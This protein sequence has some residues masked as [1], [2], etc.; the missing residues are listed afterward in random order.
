MPTTYFSGL[1]VAV[2]WGW[3][4]WRSVLGCCLAVLHCLAVG[5][6]QLAW[7]SV[8]CILMGLF[9]VLFLHS[10]RADPWAADRFQPYTRR[11][12]V[13]IRPD[14]PGF[15]WHVCSISMGL[16][17]VLFMHSH[18]ADPWA[19]DRFQPYTRRCMVCIRPDMP[20]F[21]WHVFSIHAYRGGMHSCVLYI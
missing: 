15:V 21:V 6:Y 17:I 18:R 12:M 10:H 4:G 5:S 11:C 7:L 16:F 1:V 14:M 8:A 2:L 13:C 19:A 20:G 3:V 9:I